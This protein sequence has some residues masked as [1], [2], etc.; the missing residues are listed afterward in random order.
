MVPDIAARNARLLFQ[1]RCQNSA[2]QQSK[3]FLLN[4]IVYDI[5]AGSQKT[6][7]LM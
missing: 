6:R 1:W 5:A 7:H 4:Q 3:L 2:V